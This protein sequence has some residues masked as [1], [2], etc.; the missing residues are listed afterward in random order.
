MHR[1]ARVLALGGLATLALADAAAAAPPSGI[2]EFRQNAT[3]VSA[4]LASFAS[5]T[6]G[7]D[8]IVSC[9]GRQTTAPGKLIVGGRRLPVGGGF[10]PV[11][12]ATVTVEIPRTCLRGKPAAAEKP[13]VGV[14]LTDAHRTTRLPLPDGTTFGLEGQG[15]TPVGQPGLRSLTATFDGPRRIVAI[16]AVR[17]CALQPGELVPRSLRLSVHAGVPANG[18]LTGLTSLATLDGS[19]QTVGRALFRRLTPSAPGGKLA[20]YRGRVRMRGCPE[21]PLE[22]VQF[23]F[24]LV[25]QP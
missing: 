10:V 12:G 7:E 6:R 11:A 22:G 24:A 16:E 25:R 4:K 3:V 9:G 5:L 2:Y 15:L 14:E 20:R 23:V 21:D 13:I 1:T 19:P 8:L 17:A 18:N